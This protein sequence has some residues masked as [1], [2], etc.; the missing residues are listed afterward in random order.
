M[1]GRSMEDMA[2]LAQ[3]AVTATIGERFALQLQHVGDVQHDWWRGRDKA[4][5]AA[6]ALPYVELDA[7]QW[8]AN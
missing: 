1:L 4:L 8:Q 5:A 7:I 2:D 3:M 6:L